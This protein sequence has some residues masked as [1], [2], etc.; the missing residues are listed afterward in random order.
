MDIQSSMEEMQKA[1]N[2]EPPAE[3][4]MKELEKDMTGKVHF[5]KPSH[6]T[7]VKS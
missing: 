7:F 3:E 5:R 4:D 6:L 1:Q 2:G